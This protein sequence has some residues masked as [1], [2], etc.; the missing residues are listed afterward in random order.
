MVNTTQDKFLIFLRHGDTWGD[1]LTQRGTQEIQWVCEALKQHGFIP[2]FLV[3][4]YTGRT[5]ETSDILLENFAI[6]DAMFFNLMGQPLVDIDIKTCLN[7]IPADSVCSLLSGHAE[8]V[9]TFAEKMLSDGEYTQLFGMLPE[10]RYVEYQENSQTQK[11]LM[12]RSGDAL[13]LKYDEQQTRWA[14]YAWMSR[15]HSVSYVN[16]LDVQTLKPGSKVA[17]QHAGYRRARFKLHL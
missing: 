8:T 13:I 3:T 11:T 6:K 16:D 5:V 1:E 10:G 4:S 17:S 2:D 12:V 14:L 9:E 7:S 15:E